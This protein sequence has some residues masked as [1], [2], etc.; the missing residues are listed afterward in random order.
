[1]NRRRTMHR[2][3][4]VLWLIAGPALAV[5]PAA[6]LGEDLSGLLQADELIVQSDWPER[7]RDSDGDGVVDA[8]DRCADTP[9]WV[10]LA[11]GRVRMPVDH[12]GCPVNAEVVQRQPLDLKFAFASARIEP[13]DHPVLDE[14]VRLLK[15]HPD[16]VLVLEGHTDSVGSQS[17]NLA[18]SRMRAEAVRRYVIRDPAVAQERVRAVGYGESRPV[19][20]NDSEAGRQQNRRTVAEFRIERQY[21][22]SDLEALAVSEPQNREAGS[23]RVEEDSVGRGRHSGAGRGVRVDQDIHSTRPPIRR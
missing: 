11:E 12:C 9:A 15:A 13:S 20:D 16:Q 22:R 5:S 10:E 7:T 21:S 19:A 2:Q 3:A 14:L 23:R 1:M 6:E 17:Y 8:D 18:L 4:V